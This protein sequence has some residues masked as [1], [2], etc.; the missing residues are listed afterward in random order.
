MIVPPVSGLFV[1][2][3]VGTLLFILFGA[4]GLF[5]CHNKKQLF[6]I[7]ILCGPISCFL[8][9]CYLIWYFLGNKEE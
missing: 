4:V 6:F 8:C 1:W 3:F 2:I 9:I 7:S 5:D